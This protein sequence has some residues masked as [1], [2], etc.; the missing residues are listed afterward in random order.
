MQELLK[1]LK[2]RGL[3]DNAT[4]GLEKRL[5]QGSIHGYIGFDPTATSLHVGSLVPV[6][7]LAHLQRAG[8]TPVILVGGGTGMIGDPSG[9]KSERPLLTL[10]EISANSAAVKKQLEQFLS[11]SGTNAA[12]VTNN[13]D[14]LR[15]L[16]LVEFLRD[17][18]KHFT[19]STMLQKDSVKSRLEAGISFTEFSYMLL[20]A[21]DFL[22]LYRSMD[23]ELQMGGSDQWGNITAGID[24]IRRVEGGEA[25]ALCAPLLTNASGAKFGKTET[26]NVWLDPEL[27][28]PYAFFQYW[29]N[30]DDRDVESHLKT[31]TFLARAEIN[32][33]MSRH[34]E[35]PGA[36]NAQRQLAQDV[37]TRVHGTTNTERVMTAARLVFSQEGLGTADEQVWEVLASE[38][39]SWRT[40]RASFPT[41]LI[42]LLADAGL[43]NS[44]AE[45]RRQLK[46]GGIS[47]NGEK[48][49]TE[50]PIGLE[51]LIHGR[52]M[53]LRRGKK[54]DV[55]VL[56][57]T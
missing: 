53:W 41:P 13:A 35:N 45:A 11:F 10:D 3:F 4:P 48:I 34:N 44:K 56:V 18:G 42:D 47:I 38:L 55:I 52:F 51:Q 57:D 49:A 8:G 37:T 28:S 36:R 40:A 27:T 22:H 31:F 17:T 6:M 19:I 12:R 16:S 33:I 7:L 23:C 1:E 5:I 14:W 2:W 39:R 25:H 20:Q 26:G 54:T 50:T 15:P 9:R 32:D 29:I 43:T 21:Y 30:T 46:Q 24:P